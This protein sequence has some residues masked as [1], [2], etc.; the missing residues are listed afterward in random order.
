MMSD[1]QIL[2]DV[3]AISIKLILKEPFYGHFFT[4]LI[5]VVTKE[6]P[7][8]A[9]GFNSVSNTM[10]LM[11]NPDFWTNLG[12]GEDPSVIRNYKYGLIKHEILHILFKHPFNFN[13][14]ADKTILNVAADT[15]NNQ[16]ILENQ[17]P[18]IND[19]PLLKNFKDFNLEPDK[20]T[21][22]YYSFF[23]KEKE[24]II[25]ILTQNNGKVSDL[26]SNSNWN[27]LNKSQQH[28][29]K[30]I[31]D[32]DRE[33]DSWKGS[34]NLDSGIKDFV[35]SW[36]DSTVENAI[37]KVE[38]S[39]ENKNWRGTIPGALLDYID[40]LIDSLQP[41]ANWK[42][43]LKLMTSNAKKT[44]RKTTL[45]RPSKRYGTYPGFKTKKFTKIMVAIDTS[46]SV[47]NESLCEFFSEMSHIYKAGAEIHVVECDTRIGKKWKYEGVWDRTVTG[48]GGTDFNEPIDYANKEYHP[49][50]LIYFTDGYA[51]NPRNKCNCPILWILCKNGSIDVDKMEDFQG[52]KLKMDY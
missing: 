27:T 46:G 48:R 19:I 18:C 41:V 28:L 5:R 23:K 37:K 6:I 39:D 49:D 51:P 25:K 34:G 30:F 3:D 43:V 50:C 2:M 42:R 12:K 31:T 10:T 33:H 13:K 1:E 40:D 47:D 17:L 7:T 26:E 21:D 32:Y 11:I 38:I 45:K 4:H 36:I 29:A 20:T 24:V 35:K 52:I 16:Y 15:L 8:A 22:E 14:Y 44:F 9:V